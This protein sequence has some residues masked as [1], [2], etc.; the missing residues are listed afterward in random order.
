MYLQHGRARIRRSTQQGKDES[1]YTCI[2]HSVKLT[3]P[4]RHMPPSRRDVLHSKSRLSRARPHDRQTVFIRRVGD[5]RITK[6]AFAGSRPL[7]L[8]AACR[9][10]ENTRCQPIR[11]ARCQLP[12]HR[13]MQIAWTFW[14]PAPRNKDK[15]P[16]NRRVSPG[17]RSKYPR[18]LYSVWP[19]QPHYAEALAI[20]FSLSRAPKA[21]KR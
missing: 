4:C 11:R 5:R 3:E 17:W 13:C 2:Q 8:G 9:H 6:E 1:V 16:G 12:A 19:Q 20:I 21:A 15:V 10:T 14:R 18:R 7:S